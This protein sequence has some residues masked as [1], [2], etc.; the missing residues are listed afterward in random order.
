MLKIA[1]LFLSA[2]TRHL[3]DHAESGKH[4]K[5]QPVC[6]TS[7]R[8]FPTILFG[9]LFGL[10]IFGQMISLPIYADEESNGIEGPAEG[11]RGKP[12]K[13]PTPWT[14]PGATTL[15]FAQDVQELM[16]GSDVV[17]INVSPITLSPPAL[18]GK[19]QWIQ[20]QDKP[21]HHIQGSVWLPNVGY[22]E[23][24]GGMDQYFRGN[25][26]KLT[27]SDLGR[28]LLFYCTADCW[29]SWNAVK[30]AGREYGYEQIYWYPYG[31]DGWKEQGWE[32]VPG[33]PQPF[34]E[35]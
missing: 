8:V 2:S 13:A 5:R 4:V 11:Y 10:L 12:Y 14:A 7:C 31:I 28:P 9:A 16:D 17:M 35:P 1:R 30:R 3:T 19:R 15:Y 34:S 23:L 21:M 32:L 20:R 24:D 29:M 33:T 22:Q 25:L 6:F 18:D 27:Q 26:E